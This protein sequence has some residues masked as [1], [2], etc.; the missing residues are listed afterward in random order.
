MSLKYGGPRRGPVSPY[1]IAPMGKAMPR[2]GDQS[3]HQPDALQQ[4]VLRAWVNAP[5]AM[6]WYSLLSG[7]G[8]RPAALARAASRRYKCSW[9]NVP[10]SAM[11]APMK[12]DCFVYETRCEDGLNISGPFESSRYMEVS[13]AYNEGQPLLSAGEAI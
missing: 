3:S 10:S 5:P 11:Q 2:Q 4:A 6:A 13:S 9:W 12:M 8:L 7:F 1:M